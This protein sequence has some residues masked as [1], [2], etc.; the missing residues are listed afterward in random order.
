M[1]V[2]CLYRN[3][4]ERGLTDPVVEP[5]GRR[6]IFRLLKGT[7]LDP[8]ASWGS[9]W[10]HEPYPKSVLRLNCPIPVPFIAFKWPFLDRC[11]YAGW[12]VY[13]VDA[14]EYKEWLCPDKEVFDGSLALCLSVRPFARIK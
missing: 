11:F 2:Q 13:G 1:Q 3:D 5:G 10:F 9:N 7:W 8:I 6:F 12:K 4:P 14:P